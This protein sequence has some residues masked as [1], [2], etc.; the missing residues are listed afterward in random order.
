MEFLLYDAKEFLGGT[1][2]GKVNFDMKKPV[3]NVTE[4]LGDASPYTAAQ[5]LAVAPNGVSFAVS[6]NDDVTPN[7]AA[8]IGIVGSN[9]YIRTGVELGHGNDCAYYNG[10]FYV[11]VGGDSAAPT[12][13]KRYK[14]DTSNSNKW[15]GSGTFTYDPMGGIGI[16]TAALTKVSAIA[17]VS[18]D[19]F[20]LSQKDRFSVCRLDET[21]KKFV[22]F[23][24]FQISPADW[25]KL[26]RS[27]CDK[28][29]PQGMYYAHGKVYKVFSYRNTAS[30][31]I[32][33]NDIAALSLQ[34]DSPSFNGISLD[35]QYSC[36]RTSQ[37]RFEVEGIGS[38]DG[39]TTMYMYANV[40][41]EGA[42]KQSDSIYS[43]TLQN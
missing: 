30:D 2:M 35:A 21:N 20:I 34:G 10:Y 37:H 15:V 8:L 28:P 9:R 32:K 16:P 25:A 19:N 36:D 6:L 31:A 23:S 40:R 33:Q 3:V 43:I 22:E 29:D 5:G 18:G 17:H 7:K 14:L 1:I 24:R 38:P 26:S 41:K 12:T 4:L 27:G 13:V 11:T 39:G 42:K